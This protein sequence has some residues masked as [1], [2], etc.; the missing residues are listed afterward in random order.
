MHRLTQ[1]F[2]LYCCGFVEL[3]CARMQHKYRWRVCLSVCLSH[4][5]NVSKLITVGSC[6]F[7]HLVAQFF[8]PFVP[9]VPEEHPEWRLQTR[10]CG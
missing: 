4:A 7:Q 1:V 10:L 2:V 8:K 9:Y 3:R 5:G 6:S